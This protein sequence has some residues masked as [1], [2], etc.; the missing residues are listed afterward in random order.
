MRMEDASRILSQRKAQAL[1]DAL[2]SIEF[3]LLVEILD[4]T[5]LSLEEDR[6]YKEAAYWD[7]VADRVRHE[8]KLRY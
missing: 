1:L 2:D 8:I 5:R 3:Q 4:E 7:L 6:C